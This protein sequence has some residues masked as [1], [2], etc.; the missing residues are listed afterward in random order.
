M[1]LCS[2]CLL[3]ASFLFAPTSV[4]APQIL[5]IEKCRKSAE[6]NR[7]RR[8]VASADEMGVS[9]KSNITQDFM[10]KATALENLSHGRVT[11]LKL[12]LST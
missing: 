12:W 11:L 6:E 2:T 4:C 5:D 7:L 10:Q 1:M 3:E 9:K 8:V